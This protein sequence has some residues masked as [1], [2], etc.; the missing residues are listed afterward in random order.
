MLHHQQHSNEA[1]FTRVQWPG[2]TPSHRK[3]FA[4][5]Y[6]RAKGF[7]YKGGDFV[8]SAR[9]CHNKAACPKV[10][11][12]SFAGGS[13]HFPHTER[14]HVL[15]HMAYDAQVE[16]AQAFWNQVAHRHTRF[17]LDIDCERVVRTEEIVVLTEILLAT[18][19]AYFTGFRDH[20]IPCFVAMCGPRLKH[21]TLS[22]GLHAV[23]HVN[24][25]IEQAKQLVHA[26]HLRLQHSSFDLAG[27]VVDANI[28]KKDTCNLRMVYSNKLE[29]CPLCQNLAERRHA[30]VFCRRDGRV[31]SRATYVPFLCSDTHGTVT[32]QD[33]AAKHGDYLTIVRNYSIWPEDQDT[34]HDYQ[35]PL[36]DPLLWPA[37]VVH[38]HDS[39]TPPSDTDHHPFLLPCPSTATTV[40]KRKRGSS[41]SSSNNTT[42]LSRADH[43]TRFEVLEEFLSRTMVRGQRWWSDITVKAIKLANNNRTAFIEVSGFGSTSCPYKGSDHTS[44]RIHFTLTHKGCLTVHCYSQKCKGLPRLPLALLQTTTNVILIGTPQ[45][46]EPQP[47]PKI[48][49]G[50]KRLRGSAATREMFQRRVTQAFAV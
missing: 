36:G 31:V 29:N 1:H 42:S 18:L 22:T 39:T 32:N 37:A 38:H 10:Q 6:T 47:P 17:V 41:S 33:F 25:T 45:G 7:E 11:M 30:C 19:A 43:A 2:P 46:Y 24:V 49:T 3:H 16:G 4:V 50:A 21:K 34:R 14:S 44:N 13:Y 27:V 20:T 5:Q 23:C 15:Q 48:T 26:F 8:N 28:Y 35:V 40:G 9:A 12:T